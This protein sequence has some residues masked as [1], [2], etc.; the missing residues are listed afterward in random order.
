MAG[1]LLFMLSSS[2][3]FF[4]H[5]KC[6]HFTQIKYN[7]IFLLEREIVSLLVFFV[8]VIVLEKKQRK[9]KKYLKKNYI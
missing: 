1:L 2:F 3:I 4:N 8:F 6:N 9:K 7:R 5:Q